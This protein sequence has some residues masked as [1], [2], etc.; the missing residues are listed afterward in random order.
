MELPTPVTTVINQKK[1]DKFLIR[2]YILNAYAACHVGPVTTAF[3][4]LAVMTAGESSVIITL[5]SY[6]FINAHTTNTPD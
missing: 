6:S 3:H 4:P 1:L 2:N 5:F